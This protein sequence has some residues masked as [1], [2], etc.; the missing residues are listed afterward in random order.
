ML[1]NGWTATLCTPKSYVDA[2]ASAI[3]EAGSE[4]IPATQNLQIVLDTVPGVREAFELGEIETSDE[5][6]DVWGANLDVI[7]TL[8]EGMVCL[9]AKA[10]V[11]GMAAFGSVAATLA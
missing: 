5:W 3:E 2:H 4:N 11:A 1:T 6:V 9:N 7:S 10:L 8:M